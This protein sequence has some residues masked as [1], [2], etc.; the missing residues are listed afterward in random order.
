MKAFARC[1]STIR[2]RRW[3]SVA[4]AMV[5]PPEL[6]VLELRLQL[7]VDRGIASGLSGIGFCAGKTMAKR[8]NLLA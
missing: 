2:P 1:K 3:N 5:R 4:W 7:G 8:V 6:C